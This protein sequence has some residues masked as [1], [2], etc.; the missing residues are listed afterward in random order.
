MVAKLTAVKEANARLLDDLA[1]MKGAVKGDKRA[2][3]AA[4]EAVETSHSAQLH[5]EKKMKIAKKEADNLS[6]TFDHRVAFSTRKGAKTGPFL[7]K[8]LGSIGALVPPFKVAKGE[9][10]ERVFFNWL[11]AQLPALLE[12]IDRSCKFASLFN[13][14]AS[15][16]LL[17]GRG[18]K[19][20]GSL[21]DADTVIG[22]DS[23]EGASE[24]VKQAARRILTEY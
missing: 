7:V 10:A 16:N 4:K 22:S 20:V 9:E 6:A 23:R 11:E 1:Q 8:S 21:N 5:A 19:H 24:A 2:P 12:I 18:C 17:E 3:I 13:I 15:L 14:E